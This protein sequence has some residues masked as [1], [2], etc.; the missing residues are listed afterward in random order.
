MNTNCPNCNYEKCFPAD[1]D[2]INFDSNGTGHFYADYW[3][4]VCKK[5]FRHCF[6]FNYTITEEWNR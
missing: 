1:E 2:E 3:C 5:Y 4:P 6:K